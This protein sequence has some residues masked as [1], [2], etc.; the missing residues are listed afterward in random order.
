MG[1][2]DANQSLGLEEDRKIFSSISKDP[3]GL[4]PEGKGKPK[5]NQPGNNFT[6]FSSQS[7]SG[8]L[9]NLNLT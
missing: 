8:N 1:Q 9:N 6:E 5:L 7:G 4:H 3:K 2:E